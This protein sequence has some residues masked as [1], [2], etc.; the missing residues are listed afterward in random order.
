MSTTTLYAELVVIGTGAAIFVLVLFYCL[1]GDSSLFARLGG[2][3]S[4]GSAAALIPGLSIIYLLGVINTNVGY[5]I[6]KWPEDWLRRQALSKSKHERC[7]ALSKSKQEYEVIRTKVYISQHQALI[8]DFHFRR[9]KIRICRGW[10]INALLILFALIKG[11]G[12]GYIEPF[13]ARFSIIAMGLLMIATCVSWWAA[14]DTELRELLSFD[15]A[16]R[17][18]KES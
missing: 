12:N 9:S 2:L 5:L 10:F 7:Q 4:L 16:E 18:S 17:K 11:V 8:E 14:T 3:S 13:M 15:T 1:T 6:F